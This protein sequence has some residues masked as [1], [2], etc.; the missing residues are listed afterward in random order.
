MKF[1]LRKIEEFTAQLVETLDEAE[2][3]RSIGHTLSELVRAAEEPENV[4]FK[5][6]WRQARRAAE[7]IA[8]FKRAVTGVLVPKYHEGNVVGHVRE[9]D[10]GL[11]KLMLAAQSE[12]A[13]KSTITHQGTTKKIVEVTTPKLTPESTAQIVAD[14]FKRLAAREG[15]VDA[16]YAEVPAIEDQRGD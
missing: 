9:Y 2:A 3:A 14:A 10:S 12:Y 5:H 8:A 15:A 11:L 1:S 7:R 4:E 6:R 13:P 16:E